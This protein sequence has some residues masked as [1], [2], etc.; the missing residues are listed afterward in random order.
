MHDLTSKPI[1]EDLVM[2]KRSSCVIG[3]FNAG[4]EPI[5]YTITSQHR[6]ALR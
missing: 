6:V 5:E 4:R 1:I 2:L 3:D